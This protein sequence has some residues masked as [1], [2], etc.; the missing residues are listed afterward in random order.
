M[1]NTKLLLR[2]NGYSADDA[3]IIC[4]SGIERFK[5]ERTGIL[6]IVISRDTKAARSLVDAVI[7]AVDE[8]RALLGR[9]RHGVVMLFRVD[10]H[11]SDTREAIALR[12]GEDFVISLTSAGQTVEPGAFTWAK[13]RSPLDISRDALPTLLPEF[14]KIASEA[15]F[16]AGARSADVWIRERES[17][18]FS[19]DVA[20]GKIKVKTEA[21]FAED[22][23]ARSDAAL[24]ASYEGQELIW[25]DG[26]SAQLVLNARQRHAARQRKQIEAA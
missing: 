21:E 23:Q 25:S 9:D 18:R 6:R 4:D 5:H 14:A 8:P 2:L 26:Y 7:A 24:V 11:V 1:S 13:G 20:S 15:A 17:E 19:A 22:R 10:Q 16:V 12:D 3:G